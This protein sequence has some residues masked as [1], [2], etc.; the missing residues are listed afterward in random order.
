MNF[1]LVQHG[2]AGENFYFKGWEDR[3]FSKSGGISTF[4]KVG[5]QHFPKSGGY[6]NREDK[7][8]LHTM[9]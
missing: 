8:P 6:P 4:L 3:H 2:L 5:D 1:V 7:T 9:P